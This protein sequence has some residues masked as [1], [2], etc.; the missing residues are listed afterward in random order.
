VQVNPTP[1]VI[2]L[3]VEPDN[4]V[5]LSA[6]TRDGVTK[7]TQFRILRGTEEV[8]R[9]V[10][11]EPSYAVSTTGIVSGGTVNPVRAGDRAVM[12]GQPAPAAPE[13]RKT[14]W[15]MVVG[16]AIIALVVIG[17]TR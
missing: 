10:V 8:A 14:F 16:A 7:G 11:T 13:A 17:S 9:V 15:G 4:T 12:I 1:D 5:L 6:G 2:V 3:N